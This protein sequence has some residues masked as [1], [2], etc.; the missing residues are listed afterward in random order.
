MIVAFKQPSQNRQ[1]RYASVGYE[2]DDHIGACMVLDGTYQVIDSEYDAGFLIL[3]QRAT[4][5]VAIVCYENDDYIAACVE[6]LPSHRHKPR[7]WLSN[8]RP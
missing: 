1:L 5:Q 2:N 6:S 8:P 4:A 3:S 7:R